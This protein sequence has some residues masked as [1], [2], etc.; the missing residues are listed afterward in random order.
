MPAT[1]QKK[2]AGNCIL[3]AA[4]WAVTATSTATTKVSVGL[5]AGPMYLPPGSVI[6]VL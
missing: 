5:V 1:S 4:I 2:M 6:R 3:A